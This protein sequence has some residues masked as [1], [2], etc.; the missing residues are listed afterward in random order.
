ML[1]MEAL[2]SQVLF[3]FKCLIQ[4]F[5][6]KVIASVYYGETTLDYHLNRYN[7]YFQQLEVTLIPILRQFYL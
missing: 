5:Y 2:Q 1:K 7:C 4:F 6:C 3:H